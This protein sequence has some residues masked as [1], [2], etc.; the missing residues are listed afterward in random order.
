MKDLAVAY[1]IYP[2]ISKVPA[3]HSDNKLEL[4]RLC[5][6][7]FRRAL[8]GLRFK[9]WAVLDGCPSE[10]VDLF[11]GIFSP[12]E[13]E[14]VETP[15]IGNLQTWE[16]QVDLLLGQQEAELV[17]FAEDDYFYHKDALVEM[18]EFARS[19]S[20]ADF[21][22]PYDHPDS[23]FTSSVN[24]RHKVVAS[25][26]RHWRETSSTCLTFITSRKTLRAT[27]SL[28]RSYSGGNMDCSLWLALTQK[29]EL[30]NRKV[31]AA[32]TVRLKIWAKTWL[33]GWRNILFSR[34]YHLW[35]PIPTLS[36]HM[37]STGL[38]PLVSWTD[39]FREAEL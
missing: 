32:D 38:A 29:T 9:V 26:K 25:G 35:S 27:E 8:G 18:V 34:R 24:E 31:H 7:S 3:F 2:G 15:G 22:T 28:M 10:Y 33:W 6:R 37:E 11:R 5:L 20:D 4:S 23:Y 1:R 39:E 30:M 13:L 19:H 14:I 21:I 12:D 17:M 36:T 16:R